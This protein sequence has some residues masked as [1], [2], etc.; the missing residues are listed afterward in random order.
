MTPF[1]LSIFENFTLPL[2]TTFEEQEDGL[3]TQKSGRSDR[4]REIGDILT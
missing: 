3:T 1:S 4:R 2:S